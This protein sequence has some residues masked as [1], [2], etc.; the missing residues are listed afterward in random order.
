MAYAI[1]V[2]LKD[3]MLQREA[4]ESDISLRSERL[5]AAGVGLHG[6]L[7]DKE[8][9]MSFCGLELRMMCLSQH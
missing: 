9:S 5:S 1:K 6:D 4:I 8:V 3:L 2:Q 7:L